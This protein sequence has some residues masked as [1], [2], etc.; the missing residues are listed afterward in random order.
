VQFRP[1]S[2]CSLLV[3]VGTD[4]GQAAHEDV[5]H[6]LH[7]VKA[8]QPSWLLNLQPA[9]CSV[10]VCFDPAQI[11]HEQVETAIRS[12]ANSSNKIPSTLPK[13]V[14]IPV[15]YGGEFGPDLE[16]T[17]KLL[18]LSLERL[19]EFHSAATYRASFLGFAPGFAYLGDVPAQLELPRLSTPRKKV[20][21]GSI[22]IAG[23]QTAVYPFATPGG[24]RLIGRTPLTMFR[25]DRD[26]M[27]LIGIGDQVR[28]RPITREEFLLL[29]QA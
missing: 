16:E 12:I 14:E 5:L 21:P 3:Y 18:F 25:A 15:C 7:S 11:T 9:Y 20:P 13:A 23:R 17:A 28:F 4:I 24:W 19:I 6:L 1:A 22:A 27:S 10:L 2:D 8:A 29:E 26:P